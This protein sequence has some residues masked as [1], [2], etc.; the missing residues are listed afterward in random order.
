MTQEE[1]EKIIITGLRAEKSLNE[2]HKELQSEHDVKMTF[3]DLRLLSADL[4]ID[5]D[6]LEPEPEVVEEDPAAEAAKAEMLNEGTPG[7]HV[8]VSKITRPDAALSG[9]VSFPSGLSGEWTL[10]HYGQLGM[11][12]GDTEAQPSEEEMM[13]FQNEL[14]RQLGG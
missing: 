10:D 11:D 14:R 5:W 1:I 4:D 2:I 8:E 13:D 3:M 7:L 6:A 12:L 9:S